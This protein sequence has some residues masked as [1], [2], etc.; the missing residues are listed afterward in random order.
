MYFHV[1]VI[2]MFDKFYFCWIR[3]YY[4]QLLCI[5]CYIVVCMCTCTHSYPRCVHS[6][7]PIN[8]YVISSTVGDYSYYGQNGWSLSLWDAAA[9]VKYDLLMLFCPFLFVNVII[10]GD[11]D[12]DNYDESNMTCGYSTAAIS[13]NQ[14][15]LAQPS[16]LLCP[17]T[18]TW[19]I[20]L[21]P[22]R[23]CC[24]YLVDAVFCLHQSIRPLQRQVMLMNLCA[25]QLLA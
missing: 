13:L 16:S 3:T 15:S 20:I 6:K 12:D 5:Q 1:A 19:R 11:G 25:V 8:N 4:A 21:K 17:V 10:C 23:H 14:K 9:K 24:L 2:F 7:C 18:N 22:G